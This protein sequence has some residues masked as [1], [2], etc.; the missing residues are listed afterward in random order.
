VELAT[1]TD[2][3]VRD[4]SG[5][6]TLGRTWLA[7][8]AKEDGGLTG[9]A[10]WGTPEA[11][12]TSAL[13]RALPA[14]GSPL[15]A[16]RPRLWDL[17]ALETARSEGFA[18]I[19]E[20]VA[21]YSQQL[22]RAVSRV[23]ILHASAMGGALAAGLPQVVPVPFPFEM[24]N[25]PAM[26]LSWLGVPNAQTFASEL[27]VLYATARGT[28]PLLLH[29]HAFI[30]A[31]IRKEVSLQSAASAL[32]LT[33]RTLQRRLREHGT[34]FQSEVNLARVKVAQ[35]LLLETE[36]SVTAIAFEVG[37]ASPHHFGILFRRVTGAP[38][39]RWRSNQRERSSRS[40]IRA[41]HL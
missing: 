26:A 5:R 14:E 29:L 13:L 23:A 38:P 19:A 34:S 31:H 30:A 11:D 20:H 1:S 15:A 36:T 4:P 33:S 21:T 8:C 6:Y 16:R 12:D 39:T 37:C 40:R 3:F 17:R 35:R 27:E 22:T 28:S 7:F 10:L 32:G 9:V 25:D 18:R 24:F 41:A 2:D